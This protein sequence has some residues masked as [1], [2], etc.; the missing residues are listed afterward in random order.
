M[1]NIPTADQPFVFSP[2]ALP[3][4][5][6]TT[7]ADDLLQRTRNEITTIL[8]EVAALSHQPIGFQ[9]Y[10]A[11]VLDRIVIALAAGG[12]VL[13][14]TSRETP[15]AVIRTG[16]VTDASLADDELATHDRLL[17]ELAQSRS[18]VV[19]PPT[20]A[21]KDPHLPSNP[22]KHPVALVPIL[23]AASDDDHT[24]GRDEY[25]LEVF[26]DIEGGVSTQ[27]G[28]LRFIT[29]IADYCRE[30]LQADELRSLRNESHWTQLADASIDRILKLESF[31]AI[32]AMIVDDASERFGCARAT[33]ATIPASKR[34][35]SSCHLLAVSHVEAIDQRGPGVRELRN[36]IAQTLNGTP[37]DAPEENLT[38]EQMIRSSHGRLCLFIQSTDGGLCHAGAERSLEHWATRVLSIAESQLRLESL[39][40]AR[41]YL[42]WAPQWSQVAP[43]LARRL[44]VVAATVIALTMMALI[45]TS[46]IVEL[47]ATLRAQETRIVFS[48][49]EAVIES[50][51]VT[52]G[53][54]VHQ[55][56][57]LVKLRDWQLEE[58]L[59]TLT[60]RR[61]LISQRLSRSVTSLVERPNSHL[62]PSDR[63]SE[64][65]D[66]IVQQQRLF[67]EELI[68][69]DE[70]LGILEIA[71]QRLE[72]RA[73]HDGIVDAWHIETMAVGRPVQR[74]EPLLRVIP[75]N[76][77]W[78]AEAQVE[79]SRLSVVRTRLDQTSDGGL[80]IATLAEPQTKFDAR[81]TGREAVALITG[82]NHKMQWETLPTQ[83]MEFALTV[84]PD[85]QASDATMLSNRSWTYGT[86][87]TVT[88]DCGR[89]PLVQ[90]ALY[91]F[92]R[93]AQRTLARWI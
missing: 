28:Y 47:P 41:W 6:A 30:F 69:I 76:A 53:Q 4:A 27:R 85:A 31:A 7:L 52:H 87:A 8:R 14:N 70:Q 93:A 80:Q 38:A 84:S 25:L 66:E 90:V 55:G 29:Q 24:T 9:A 10:F 60:A 19:V 56:D 79:Q 32:A 37:P 18:P 51:P 57:L 26:L 64:S 75:K 11:A 50:A 16:L 3:S 61:A 45:P 48:P 88:V 71:R 22:T 21:V 59:A 20:P 54:H 83:M 12:A 1:V 65:D 72:L 23:R 78:I 42:A 91:D 77:H 43:T 82:G 62:H 67:E 92:I 81:F 49:S 63:T 89:K 17:Q 36:R 39:P 33:L 15:L 46:M 68:G 74:G 13:W 44:M 40:L 58:K 73:D 34:R 35:V 86:P 5:T 2:S